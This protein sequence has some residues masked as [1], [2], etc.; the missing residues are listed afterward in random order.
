MFS[1]RHLPNPSGT[2]GITNKLVG[3]KS[4]KADESETIL[5]RVYGNKTDLLIDRKAE[6]RN[7]I[8]LNR[9]GLAPDLFATFDNGLAYRFIPGNTLNCDTIIRPNIYYLVAKR[10]ANLHNVLREEKVQPEPLI[11]NK[12]QQFLDLVPDVFCDEK[13]QKR[14][15][16][17][18]THKSK[19]IQEAMELRSILEKL[20]T[21]IVFAHNDLLLGNVIYTESKD[22]VT[23]IDYEYA[24]FNYQAYDIGNH[25]IEFAGLESPDFAKY[26]TKEFQRDWLKI[27]LREFNQMEPS[28]LEIEKLYVEVNQFALLAHIFWG[29]WSLIQAEHS[30]IEFDYIGYAAVRFNEYFYRKKEFL[31]LKYPS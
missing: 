7:I 19:I 18:V 5:V 11:W 14:Y 8:L 3:C 22:T 27:Y 4:E 1:A 10:M 31:S 30:Y 2:D 28:N 17:S 25:F 29:V 26:P 23:F 6:T 20:N 9:A 13:K 24:G 15:Q 21:P 12:L 16:T